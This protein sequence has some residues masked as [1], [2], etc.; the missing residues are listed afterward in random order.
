MSLFDVCR[1]QSDLEA[2]LFKLMERR[3]YGAE[4]IDRYKMMTRYYPVCASGFL[5]MVDRSRMK[6]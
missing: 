5:K 6:A 3:G 1:S 2:N 4:Y